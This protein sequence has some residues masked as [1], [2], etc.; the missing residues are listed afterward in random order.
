MKFHAYNQ[1]IFNLSRTRIS[2]TWTWSKLSLFF[3]IRLA[4]CVICNKCRWP[5]VGA[6]LPVRG[7][8]S[9]KACGVES[10][11]SCVERNQKTLVWIGTSRRFSRAFGAM[12]RWSV[13]LPI[14]RSGMLNNLAFL[15]N[16]VRYRVP[17][18][19]TKPP[20]QVFFCRREL[21][22]ALDIYIQVKFVLV[23]FMFSLMQIVHYQTLNQVKGIKTERRL[24]LI[25]WGS[26]ILF[27]LKSS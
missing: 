7:R 24:W 3:E 10:K 4:G 8:L 9:E 1:N 12:F 14:I 26:C 15:C 2:K 13:D 5:Y 21:T 23:L 6:F 17:W 11:D 19:L 16:S 27:N 22:A 18:P 20:A 25:L